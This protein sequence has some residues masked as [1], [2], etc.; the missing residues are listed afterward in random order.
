[1]PCVTVPLDPCRRPVQTCLFVLVLLLWPQHQLKVV[2]HTAVG[3]AEKVLDLV[4]GTG[5]LERWVHPYG[6][7]SRAQNSDKDSAVQGE[8]RIRRTRVKIICFLQLPEV[9]YTM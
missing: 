7:A 5:Q 6:D 9:R 4:T 1:M 3:E 2:A 8:S